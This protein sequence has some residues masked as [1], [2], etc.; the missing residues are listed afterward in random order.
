[1]KLYDKNFKFIIEK[2]EFYSFKHVIYAAV[3]I[4]IDSIG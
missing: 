2:E 1:M 3:Y 4:T